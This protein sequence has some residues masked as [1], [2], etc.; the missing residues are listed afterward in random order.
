MIASRL[1]GNLLSKLVRKEKAKEFFGFYNIFGKFASVM[2]PLL[3]GVTS[4]MTGHLSYG[5]FSLVILF[6]IGIIVLRFVPEP[7]RVR[8]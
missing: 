3:V 5:V 4:Q 2:G 7:D 8:I 1:N 6:I